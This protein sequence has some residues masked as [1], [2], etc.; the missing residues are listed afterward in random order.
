L[1]N[2][3]TFKNGLF[4]H[5]NNIISWNI[6]NFD[7][8]KIKIEEYMDQQAIHPYTTRPNVNDINFHG[9]FEQGFHNLMDICNHG[10]LQTLI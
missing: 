5:L 6:L 8:K 1:I 7:Q 4:K 10:F 3:K 9:Q 2:E